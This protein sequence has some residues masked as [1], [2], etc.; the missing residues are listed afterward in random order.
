MLDL[1]G[2]LWRAFK[3]RQIKL[4]EDGIGCDPGNAIMAYGAIQDGQD[5][6]PGM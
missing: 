2:G 5:G 3:G 1:F 6:Y 4:F